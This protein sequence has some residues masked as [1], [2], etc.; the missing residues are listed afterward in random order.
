LPEQLNNIQHKR[1]NKQQ[2]PWQKRPKHVLEKE[3]EGRTVVPGIF[4]CYP[5]K[6]LCPE[7]EL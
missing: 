2:N 7:K 6:A 1:R 3:A 5:A 4:T